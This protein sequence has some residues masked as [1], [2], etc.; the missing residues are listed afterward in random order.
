MMPIMLLASILN[1]AHIGSSLSNEELMDGMEFIYSAAKN[2][3]LNEGTVIT[4]LT[5][6]RTKRDIWKKEFVWAGSANVKP[7]DFSMCIFC[8]FRNR[9]N[10]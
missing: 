8:S 4:E 6:Y 1:P 10:S 5:N 7:I 9:K 2:V 3:G